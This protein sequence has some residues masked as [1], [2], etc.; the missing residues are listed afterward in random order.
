MSRSKNILP[1]KKAGKDKDGVQLWTPKLV[2][3]ANHLNGGFWCKEKDLK[4]KEPMTFWLREYTYHDTCWTDSAHEAK[5]HKIIE[6]FNQ[7]V[8]QGL[9]P[10]LIVD[11]TCPDVPFYSMVDASD[12]YLR[13]CYLMVQE[14][15]K[16]DDIYDDM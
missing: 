11:Y 4:R 6:A 16:Y 15:H 2:Y 12:D 10:Q 3:G 13:D 9:G 8:K 7:E 5:E 1:L 14:H